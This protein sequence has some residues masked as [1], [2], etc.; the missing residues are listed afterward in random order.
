MG[1]HRHNV[2][3][4]RVPYGFCFL[5]RKKRM[6]DWWIKNQAAF[7][8]RKILFLNRNAAALRGHPDFTKRSLNSGREYLQVGFRV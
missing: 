5:A 8:A 1:T 2:D 3:I 6:S 4:F 7:A